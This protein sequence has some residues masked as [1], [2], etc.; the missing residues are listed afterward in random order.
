MD[1]PA[2]SSRARD[3][4]AV[5]AS[6]TRGATAR[7][8]ISRITRSS[9]SCCRPKQSLG[10]ELTSRVPADSRAEHG[11]D[12]RPSSAGEVLRRARAE[13]AGSRVDLARSR[14]ADDSR[15]LPRR[16]N[17]PITRLSTA[18]WGRCCTRKGVFI[19]Q[20]YDELNV[21]APDLVRD[22]HRAVREGRRRGA[23]DEQLRREPVEARAVRARRSRCTS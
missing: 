22:V 9:S 19:N 15:R 17:D 4:P 7:V 2:H 21:R 23:R 8:P 10:M 12:H 11:R 14:H 3:S 20:C 5:R 1:A 6:A 16:L 18:R 13:G